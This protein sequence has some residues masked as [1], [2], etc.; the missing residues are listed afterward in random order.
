M[1]NFSKKSVRL[2]Y[3]SSLAVGGI[4][5]LAYV[6]SDNI[7]LCVKRELTNTLTRYRMWWRI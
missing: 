1:Q 4:S 6:R 5:R 2:N 7:M 3:V